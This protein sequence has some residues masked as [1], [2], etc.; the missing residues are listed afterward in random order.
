MNR[1]RLLPLLCGVLACWT[2]WADEAVDVEPL[3]ATCAGCHGE[4]GAA[5]TQPEYPVLAGQEFYYLYV[6]LK[7]YNSGLRE[8]AVMSPIAATLDK[9]QMKALAMHFSKQPWPDYEG[10]V[11]DEVRQ[12]AR[13]AIGAG[14]C[15]AC[16]LGDFKGNSRVP[17][18]AGQ[19][20]EYLDA[21]MVDFKTKARN[22][23]AAKSSLMA[24][25]G[26]EDIEHMA[27][28]LAT[29]QLEQ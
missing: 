24:S 18:L 16:H 11:S 13:S 17:R 12:A 6:Q 26:E 15:V 19:R 1:S 22:N 29:V 28:Y 2:A 10:T 20:A 21:T 23:A 25:F 14:Q 7:D 3:L 9:D 4:N 27:R 8:N 5:P